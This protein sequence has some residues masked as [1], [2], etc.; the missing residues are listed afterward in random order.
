MASQGS[1]LFVN[2]AYQKEGNKILSDDPEA[3]N[4]P[5]LTLS[6]GASTDVLD[7]HSIGGNISYIGSRHN[8][9]GYSIVNI[10]YTARL[11]DFEL[12]VVV[13]NIMNEEIL[14]PDISTQNSDLV[15]HGE[16]GVNFQLGVR[17]NF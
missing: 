4:T 5:R 1:K 10:N 13:R 16:E 6:I 15:A 11:T 2:L 7:T 14:N 9:D 8:L 17:I 12:F 3:F